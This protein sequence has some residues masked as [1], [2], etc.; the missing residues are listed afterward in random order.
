MLAQIRYEME[1]FIPGNLK[2]TCQSNQNDSK[3]DWTS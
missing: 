3:L 1:K 2:Q